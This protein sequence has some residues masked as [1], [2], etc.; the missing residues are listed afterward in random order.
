[1]S[2][3]PVPY[4]VDVVY[5]PPR[6]LLSERLEQQVGEVWRVLVV[7]AWHHQAD[8]YEVSVWWDTG[9]RRILVGE[10]EPA[11]TEEEA[12][13]VFNGVRARAAELL[14]EQLGSLATDP[15]LPPGTYRCQD[16]GRLADWDAECGCLEAIEPVECHDCCGR[17]W[18]EDEDGRFGCLECNGEG[19]V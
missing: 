4:G 5:I 17:G 18:H 7:E 2:H 9:P 11:A 12:L 10:P 8:D 15:E 6:K 14:V 3:P 1:M 19:L 13:E 16:C